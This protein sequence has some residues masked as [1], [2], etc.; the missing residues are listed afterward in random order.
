MPVRKITMRYPVCGHTAL[1]GW[2]IETDAVPKT[3]YGAIGAAVRQITDPVI[4]VGVQD[5]PGVVQDGAVTIGNDAAPNRPHASSR[6]P[7]FAFLPPLHPKDL[8]DPVFKT[9]HGLKYPYIVGAMA[10]GITSVAMVEAAGKAGMVGFFGAAG[11]APE[12]I[13][14]AISRLHVHQK[15]FPVG[16]NLI[17]SPNEPEL[18]AATVGLYLKHGVR[19]ISASAYMDMTLPL[20]YYRVKGLHR[21]AG[22]DIISPNQVIAKVSR[23]EVARKFFAPPPERLLSQ[24]VEKHMISRE[25][26]SLAR[27]I[28]MAEDLT[29]E[30][31]SGGHTDNRPAI[32]LLP[33]MLAVRADSQKKY[34]YQRP[35]CVG[36]AGGIATPESAAAAFSM[37]AAYVLTGSVNQA[38][39][40][41]GTSDA[42]RMMLAEAGQ[43]DVTMAPAADMFE[44]GVKV[45]VLKRGTMFALRAAKL[46]DLYCA[47]DSLDTLPQAQKE[48]LERDFFRIRLAEVW[49]MTRRYFSGRD[50]EQIERAEKDPKH[51]MA[52]VFRWYLGQSSGWANS[53]DPSRKIDYQIW[54]G[55]AIGAFNEWVKGSFLEKTENRTVVGIAMNILY[56][57]AVVMRLNWLKSHGIALPPD[58]T[59]LSPQPVSY[60]SNILQQDL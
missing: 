27:F 57:A 9:A 13:E 33:T 29:A 5:E 24:L 1:S 50:P 40:E 48:I 16:F 58:M 19:R 14:S 31:D 26:A 32:S 28:P 25:E 47:H 53:G 22:G 49:A 54:C 55:P 8:G 15:K 12:D 17:Y 42:V 7:L 38:C 30:A 56:G 6:Y 2:W 35:L 37:G 44:M 4:V 43:A 20:V 10:N 18:E 23:V 21:L 51:K 45:Q 39:M 11:L 3:G 46:Y 41:A 52:L 60:L 36:L 34:S 59:A